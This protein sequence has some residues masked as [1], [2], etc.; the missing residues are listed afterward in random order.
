MVWVIIGCTL[1]IIVCLGGGK[2][3]AQIVLGAIAILGAV[4]FLGSPPSDANLHVD[5]SSVPMSGIVAVIF[6]VVF[7]ALMAYRQRQGPPR[8]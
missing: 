2:R 8:A 7:F 3:L 4:I 5:L 1:L 6:V